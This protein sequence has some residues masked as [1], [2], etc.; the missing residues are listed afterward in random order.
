MVAV[1]VPYRCCLH[2][3]DNQLLRTETAELASDSDAISWA[4]SLATQFPHLPV[5]RVWNQNRLVVCLIALSI[6]DLLA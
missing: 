3:K 4:Q 5:V 2:N 6:L 1:M